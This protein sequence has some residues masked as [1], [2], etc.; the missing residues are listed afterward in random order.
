VLKYHLTPTLQDAFEKKNNCGETDRPTGS[1]DIMTS[2]QTDRS[3]DNNGRS[4]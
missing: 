4:R 2:P 3:T 1:L